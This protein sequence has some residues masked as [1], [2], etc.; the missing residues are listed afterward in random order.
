MKYIALL[1]LNIKGKIN[2]IAIIQALYN[3][4]LIHEEISLGIE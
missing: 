1:V 4:F 3:Q 2:K